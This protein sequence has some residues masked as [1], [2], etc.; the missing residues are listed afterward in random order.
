[1]RFVASRWGHYRIYLKQFVSSV[2][3]PPMGGT[4]AYRMEGV[5]Y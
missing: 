3:N 1:M 5:Q 4:V 2:G